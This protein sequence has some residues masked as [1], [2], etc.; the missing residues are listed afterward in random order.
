MKTFIRSKP[1]SLLCIKIL[2]L[3]YKISIKILELSYKIGIELL[4]LIR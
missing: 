1:Y 4:E 3:S 2:E